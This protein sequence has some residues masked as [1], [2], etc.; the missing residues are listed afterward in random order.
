MNGVVCEGMSKEAPI[1]L[2]FMEKLIGLL[3]IAVGALW[4]YTTYTN[5]G[6][7]DPQ[8]VLFLGIALALIILGIVLFIAKAE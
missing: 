3:M 8:S 7:L 4:F 5:I 1:G 2:T 6:S